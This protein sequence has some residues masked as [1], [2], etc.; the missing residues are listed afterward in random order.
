MRL[1]PHRLLLGTTLLALATAAPL[2]AQRAL[3]LSQLSTHAQLYEVDLQTAQ[4]TPLA[5]F[6]GDTD[7][8][9]TLVHD[10]ASD[11]VI[12]ALARGKS[13]TVFTRLSYAGAQLVR[14]RPL[15]S[16]TGIATDMILA[17]RSAIYASVEG[18]DGLV[19]CER[20]G[21]QPKLTVPARACSH[22][23]RRSAMAVDEGGRCLSNS[24]PAARPS[25]EARA[26]AHAR[27]DPARER[28]RARA[29]CAAVPDPERPEPQQPAP[30]DAVA[31]RLLVS[32]P[33]Q[34]FARYVATDASPIAA[35]RSLD[36]S[37]DLTASAL[38]AL[39]APP[40]RHTHRTS[41]TRH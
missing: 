3:V 27:P 13:T 20:V 12:V 32:A 24:A 6:P 21:P 34:K 8:A 36:R 29:L 35:S 22:S 19:R 11:D 38:L 39:D 30:A 25:S 9:L 40:R 2:V 31:R 28:G 17:D 37:P 33:S 1:L 41:A 5:R 15:G 10:F 23:S 4:V 16:V 7:R 14:S 26:S 18:P